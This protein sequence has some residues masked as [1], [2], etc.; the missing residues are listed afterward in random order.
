M[1]RRQR[2]CALIADFR[3]NLPKACGTGESAT[4]PGAAA[5]CTASAAL[6]AEAFLNECYL[7]APPAAEGVVGETTCGVTAN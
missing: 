7:D 3:A 6:E 5:D 2:L 4:I 1:W